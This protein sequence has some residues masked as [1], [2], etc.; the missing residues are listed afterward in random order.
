[1]E[2]GAAALAE[3]AAGG[4]GAAAGFNAAIEERIQSRYGGEPAAM[5]TEMTSGTVYG[6][7]LFTY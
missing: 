1:L 2:A 5:G 6:W 7:L 4:A 3:A